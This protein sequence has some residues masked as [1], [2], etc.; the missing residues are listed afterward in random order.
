MFNLRCRKRERFLVLN[1][2]H[3]VERL[4]SS[5]C[6]KTQIAH[7]ETD[8][9]AIVAEWNSGGRPDMKYVERQ[10]LTNVEYKCSRTVQ[11]YLSCYTI[12]MH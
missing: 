11:Q 8:R 12:M 1:S 4:L 9:V 5:W 2:A 7:I 10:K 3:S 6:G